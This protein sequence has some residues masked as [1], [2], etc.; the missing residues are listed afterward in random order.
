MDHV[1]P[2]AV[3]GRDAVDR[4]HDNDVGLARRLV[5]GLR[6]A[7]RDLGT[8][9]H[10]TLPR[11]RPRRGEGGQSTMR[12]T[13]VRARSR[14]VA[15]VFARIEQ[16][17]NFGRI[18]Q[19]SQTLVVGE[20]AARAGCRCPRPSARMRRHRRFAERFVQLLPVAA[21][22]R[23]LHHHRFGSRERPVGAQILGDAPLVDAQAADDAQARDRR[24]RRCT[25]QRF[26][27]NRAAVRAVVERALE[28]VRRR[29]LPGDV[30]V[31]RQ[32]ARQRVDPFG[33]HRIAFER[34]RRTADLLSPNGSN[35][36]PK[37]GDER[38]RTS[39]AN[40]ESEAPRPASARAADS[41][42]C[43]DRFAC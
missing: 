30:G 6:L 39:A 41:R 1:A 36:S 28:E 15:D 2:R 19:R 21:G 12:A 27:K 20:E 16:R 38:M 8:F 35:I 4:L 37:P 42:A 23:R 43:A 14:R 22:L 3:A 25:E 31:R 29:V 26:R 40:F 24:S 11:R 10:G 18:E 13:S 33:E 34:H 7:A 17:A 5:E 32:Q 9:V